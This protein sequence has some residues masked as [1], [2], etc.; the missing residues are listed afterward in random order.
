M[1]QGASSVSD[2]DH[3]VTIRKLL[4]SVFSVLPILIHKWAVKKNTGLILFSPD[5]SG[6][7]MMM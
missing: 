1:N 3:Y 2:V 4:G 6:Y 7:M 5:G